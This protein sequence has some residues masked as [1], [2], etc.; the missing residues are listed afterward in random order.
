VLGVQIVGAEASDLIAAAGLAVE[1]ALH[2][3][4]VVGTV[5][6]H[7]T[8]AESFHEAAVAV[9]R[10]RERAGGAGGKG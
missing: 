4:D 3:D 5:H 1:N 6:A 2:V 8:L 7:P 10:R 9:Q